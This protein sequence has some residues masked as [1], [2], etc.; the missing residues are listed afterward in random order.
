MNEQ[1]IARLQ[2]LLAL[3][4]SDNPN[5]AALAM[6]RAQALMREHDL[7]LADVALDGSGAYVQE[8]KI[9]SQ[10]KTL[11]WWE[12][13][14]GGWIAEAFD[15]QV[16]RIASQGYGRADTL[17][18][19]ATRTDLAIIVD[20]F[21]R[22]RD[23]I[24]RQAANHAKIV[25]GNGRKAGKA[26]RAGMLN[27]LGKRLIALRDNTRPAPDSRTATGLTGSEL[28]VIK[29]KAVM[30]RLCKIYPRFRF[31][32]FGQNI[33]PDDRTS[34]AQGLADGH[35]VNLHRSVDG[36]SDGSAYLDL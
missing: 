12:W 10:G 8:S 31:I 11:A 27:T 18:F 15:G 7:S 35:K 23:T 4:G 16:I 19:I 30:Q 29:D 28:L 36:R 9:S 25:P 14:M 20:L 24:N 22:L 32:K 26:Y 21:D 1:V 2:K 34:Y 6:E 5:E 3:A 33:R 13:Q 17:H